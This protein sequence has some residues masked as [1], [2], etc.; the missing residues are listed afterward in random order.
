MY[1]AYAFQQKAMRKEKNVSGS[2]ISDAVIYFTNLML[3]KI[4]GKSLVFMGLE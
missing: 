1:Q 4:R 3:Q 2:M